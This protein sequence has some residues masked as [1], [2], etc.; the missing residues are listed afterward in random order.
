MNSAINDGAQPINKEERFM[1]KNL[2]DDMLKLV[3]YKILFVKRDYEHA[4]H[5]D[6]EL[7]SDNINGA[8][9]TAW[10]I[11]QFIQKLSRKPREV[12]VPDKWRDKSYPSKAEHALPYSQTEVDKLKKAAEAAWAAAEKAKG[13]PDEQAETDKAKEAEKAY[14]K[15]TTPYWLIGFPEEDK[16]HLRVFYEVLERY[17]REKFRYEERQIEVLEEIRDKMPGK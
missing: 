12:R 17:P 5:Q 15:A 14:K 3:R 11:A 2:N 4:L 10:K 7:V 6:E 16:K 9:F 8:D 1:D 13:H